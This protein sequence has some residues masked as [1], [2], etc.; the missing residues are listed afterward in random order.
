MK[1]TTGTFVKPLAAFSI[2]TLIFF[3]CK[4]DSNSSQNNTTD[5]A[6]DSAL[7]MSTSAAASDNLYNDVY[8]VL[9]QTGT[10]NAYLS[11]R[12]AVNGRAGSADSVPGCTT[13]TVSPADIN[14]YPKTVV[15]NFGTGCTGWYGVT[16][17]GSITYSLTDKFKNPGSVVTAAFSNYKVNGYKL[18]GN[19][20]V[21]NS[22]SIGPGGIIVLFNS[23]VTNGKVTYPDGTTW[24]SYSGTK[25][26][27]Q[28]AGIGSTNYNDY[29][30]AITGAHSYASFTGKTLTDSIT[31]PL[32]KQVTC[33]N[34]SAGTVA[35][36][37]NGTIKGT[38]DYGS[39]TCDSLATI[40]IGTVTKTIGLPR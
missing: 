8:D 29:V 18:E 27:R 13:I 33:K 16:R 40:T 1:I 14:T 21:T 30:F 6:S 36:T 4:K 3:S 37:Y 28:T 7:S 22:S 34:I 23:S 31:T 19:Y 15:V 32:V 20:T 39:G 12:I 25:S 38:L 26:I 11:G 5:P 35:F 10:N 2:C 9:G 17:S 24:Y